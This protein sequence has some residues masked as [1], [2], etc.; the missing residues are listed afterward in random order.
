MCI[1]LGKQRIWKCEEA[2][3]ALSCGNTGYVRDF[4]LTPVCNKITMANSDV[5]QGFEE[6]MVCLYA[7]HFDDCLRLGTVVCTQ[8]F[9]DVGIYIDIYTYVN[10][11]T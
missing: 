2:T 11:L 5:D 6:M 3:S 9:N 7:I 4:C 8:Y 1:F 10:V